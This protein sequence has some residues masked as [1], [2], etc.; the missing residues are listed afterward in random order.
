MNRGVPW[1]SADVRTAR[2]LYLA[3]TPIREIAAQLGRTPGGVYSVLRSVSH[4]R[5]YRP[6]R[7]A[8][9]DP[10]PAAAPLWLQFR[11]TPPAYADPKASVRRAELQRRGNRER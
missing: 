8:S 1:K 5:Q 11:I 2:R 4:L 10:T 3:S 6:A 7:F 9:P